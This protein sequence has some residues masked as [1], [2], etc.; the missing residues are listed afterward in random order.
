VKP[1]SPILIT[2][3]LILCFA[4]AAQA[5]LATQSAVTVGSGFVV[6]PA[7]TAVISVAIEN[8][9][10]ESGAAHQENQRL[11]DQIMQAL[12]A[13]QIPDLHF[14]VRQ[15]VFWENTLPGSRDKTWKVSSGLDIHTSD[16]SAAGHIIDIARKNGAT[17]V[18]TIRYDVSNLE[19]A[20]Q[21][22]LQLAVKD[23]VR[24]AEAIAAAAGLRVIM[25]REVRDSNAIR[26]HNPSSPTATGREV[27][28]P[29]LAG[30][31]YRGEVLVSVEVTMVFDLALDRTSPSAGR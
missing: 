27:T 16:L 5:Q 12:K 18:Q 29:P 17:S 30:P 19:Q 13:E 20:A 8:V 22:A 24:K 28:L 3:L 21:D 26:V 9:A 23:A 2:L 10:A 25:V 4:G 11:T 15:V 14:T 31:V 1:P 6:V 7:D